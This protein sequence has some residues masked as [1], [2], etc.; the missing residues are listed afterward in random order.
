MK[1]IPQ[2]ISFTIFLGVLAAVPI[3]TLTPRAFGSQ[4]NQDTTVQADQQIQSDLAKE[5]N[6]NRF[7]NIQVK[8]SNGVIDLRGTVEI[9]A[10]KEEA[11]RKA[12]HAKNAIAVRNGIV[13]ADSSISDQDLQSKLVEKLTY[14]RLGYG[15]TTF[16]AIS[17]H[18]RGGVVTLGGHAYSPIDKYSALS[19]ASYTPG[20]Q[21]VIDEIEV[22]PASPM[23]DRIRVNVARLIYGYP[24]LMKYSI[25]PARPI[26]ISVQNGNVTLFGTVDNAADR[27]AAFIRANSAQG[28]FKVN[29][30]LTVENQVSERE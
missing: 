17:I 18:V 7:K 22:D 10:D 25:D 28:V 23:D 12:H 8:V 6:R 4:A 2:F 19:V 3:L 1:T 30:E 11:E 13:V 9:F 16:N 20:V 24:S 21:D 5:F 15:S 27:D 29:N 26:R 14:D